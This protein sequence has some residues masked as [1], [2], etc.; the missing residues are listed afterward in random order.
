MANAVQAS[1]VTNGIEM[2]IPLAALGSPTGAIAICAFIGNNG[3]GLQM[4]DQILGP[5]GNNDPTFCTIAPGKTT[6]MPY[7]V[8]GN[9]PGQHYFYV[10]PEMRVT[11]VGVSNNNVNISYQTENNTNLLYRVERITGTT[12]PIPFGCQFRAS[13][14]VPV[15]LSRKPTRSGA[16]T[17]RARSIGS[18]NLRTAS[19]FVRL[20][21]AP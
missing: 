9:Y 10:G 4:S 13:P 18:G 2:A 3:N 1:T 14:P 5:F 15:G 8:L 12:R 20:E 21:I 19:E 16:R 11:G 17:N 7:V 6:N